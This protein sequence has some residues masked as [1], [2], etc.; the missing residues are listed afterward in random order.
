MVVTLAEV[1]IPDGPACQRFRES[2]ASASLG[3]HRATAE[4]PSTAQAPIGSMEVED[5]CATDAQVASTYEMPAAST[6]RPPAVV[7]GR[8]VRC[9]SSGKHETLAYHHRTG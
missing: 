3:R 6:A 7:I 5:G 2:L 9:T 8:L 1:P 4:L